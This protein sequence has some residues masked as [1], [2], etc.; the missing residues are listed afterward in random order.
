MTRHGRKGTM[1]GHGLSALDGPE[2]GHVSV[3]RLNCPDM[4]AG[5][6]FGH[7]SDLQRT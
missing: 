5:R 1:R 3:D 6:L 4:E 7:L 2:D